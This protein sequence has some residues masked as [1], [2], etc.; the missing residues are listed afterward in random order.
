MSSRETSITMP[1]GFSPIERILLTANGNVQRILSAYY[2]LPVTV[3]ILRNDRLPLPSSTTETPL[4]NGTNGTSSPPESPSAP[5]PPL[6]IFDRVVQLIVDARVVCL[7]SSVVHITDPEY[8]KLMEEENVGIGQLFRFLNVL[9]EFNLRAVGRIEKGGF[10][11]TY[12][13][14]SRGVVCRLREE[15]GGIE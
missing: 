5:T 2:N 11:R 14:R 8:L 9:P 15:F 4:L 10:W 7:A 12:E 3:R 1:K 6:A 13:L